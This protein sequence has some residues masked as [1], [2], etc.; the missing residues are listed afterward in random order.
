MSVV[1]RLVFTGA[2]ALWIGAAL[3]AEP[4]FT[5][6][7]DGSAFLYRARPGDR[8]AAVAAMFGIA[9]EALP[10]FLAANGITDP[11]RVATGHVYRIPNPLAARTA[12]AEARAE[13]LERELAEV[14]TRSDALDAELRAVRETARA[15]E[16]QAGRLA[17]LEWLWPVAEGV[18]ALLVVALGLTAAYA[19]AA[20]R[21]Q[22]E[23]GRYART[24]AGEIEEKR[25]R[26]LA[27]RQEAAKRILDLEAEVRELDARLAAHPS[28]PGRRSPAGVR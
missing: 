9:P 23:A 14:R 27:E 1:R 15:A 22:K 6:T 20:A 3:A 19:S 4:L 11:T 18:G 26:G 12:G 2:L 21:K 24:L 5:L 7:D 16:R 17:R 10:A 25:R 8:P 13:A 28:P